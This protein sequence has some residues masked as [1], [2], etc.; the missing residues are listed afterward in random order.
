MN[1]LFIGGTGV[2]SRA[3]T[4]A[5]LERGDKVFLLNR[6]ESPNAIPPECHH[7]QADIQQVEHVNAL[8]KDHHFDCVVDWIAYTPAHIERESALF[9]GKTDQYIFISSASIYAKPP[10]LPIQ[11]THPI[12]NPYWEY[13]HNKILCEQTLQ[14][15]DD[16][17]AFPFTIVRPSH[18]YD[19]TKIPLR[20]GVT[21][22]Q[23]LL[24]GKPVIVHGDG[25][26]LWT[27]THHRDFAQGFVGLLGHPEALGQTYHITSDEVLTW[28][29]IYHIMAQ[30]AGVEAHLFHLASETILQYDKEW[31]D[32]LLGDKAHNMVF[33][34]SK[35]KQLN[36]SYEAQIPF[37]QGAREILDWYQSDSSHQ[38]IDLNLDTL[39]DQII[40]DRTG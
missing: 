15:M 26:T 30:T 20:G 28:N 6:G 1:I 18:T 35:I 4:Q 13:A 12:H 39:M 29:Q 38:R 21:S 27:L 10:R 22:L 14:R 33:D 17:E 32:G 19:A 36:P 31:G 9:R 2:I 40:R 37:A 7:F 23:R 5:C 11:E 25:T 16:E 24:T 8:M 3:C 34:N